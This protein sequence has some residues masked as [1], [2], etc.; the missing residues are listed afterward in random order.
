MVKT[1]VK[2]TA[3]KQLLIVN[4]TTTHVISYDLEHL[5]FTISR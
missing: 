5:E 3:I 2:I 4:D 1:V